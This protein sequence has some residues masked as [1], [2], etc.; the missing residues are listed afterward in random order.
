MLTQGQTWG[1][2]IVLSSARLRKNYAGRAMGFLEVHTRRT[3]RLHLHR[4]SRSDTTILLF[5]AGATEPP[6]RPPHTRRP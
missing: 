1:E 5:S 2:D 3:R 6:P 4:R